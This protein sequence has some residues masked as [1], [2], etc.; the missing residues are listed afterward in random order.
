MGSPRVPAVSGSRNASPSGHPD[1]AFLL[2]RNRAEQGPRSP[3]GALRFRTLQATPWNRLAPG[4]GAARGLGSLWA[5]NR[6][7]GLLARLPPGRPSRVGSAVSVPRAEGG[8]GFL[9]QVGPWPGLRS[10]PTP[11]ANYIS[12]VPLPTGPLASSS[13]EPGAGAGDWMVAAEK[14]PFS[15]GFS[16]RLGTPPVVPGPREGHQLLPVSLQ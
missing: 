11:P 1:R 12:Q 5:G 7:R 14:N 13:I 8:A 10:L 16:S 2:G 3:G 15:R 9:R 4:L 6:P